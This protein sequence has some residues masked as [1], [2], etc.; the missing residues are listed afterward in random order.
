MPR[1]E[2]MYRDYLQI[3]PSTAAYKRGSVGNIQEHSKM[4]LSMF[5][6]DAK[7]NESDIRHKT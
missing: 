2:D 5:R 7:G 4:A 3:E 6:P 1:K